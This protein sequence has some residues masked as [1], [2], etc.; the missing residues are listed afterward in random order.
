MPPA[1]LPAP[2]AGRDPRARLRWLDLLG[3][4]LLVVVAAFAVSS[5]FAGPLRLALTLPLLLFAPGFL[6]LQAV[7]VPPASGA[8]LARQALA[9]MGI[10]PAVVGL[11]ALA[12]AIVAGG[13]TEGAIVGTVTVG[14]LLF[15]VIALQRRRHRVSAPER[16]PRRTSAPSPGANRPGAAPALA[17]AAAAAPAGSDAARAKSGTA[18]P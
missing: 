4:A 14:S 18:R 1:G 6:L 17:V 13:F 16:K 9:S 12:T 8:S 5:D 15:A 2:K 11:F 3:A 7:V 10:S